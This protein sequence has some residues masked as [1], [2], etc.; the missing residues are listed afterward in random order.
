MSEPINHQDE[1]LA[2]EAL[3]TQPKKKRRKSLEI[4]E[5]IIVAFLLAVF[6]RATI[7]EARYIPSGS[8]LPSLQVGDRLIVEKLTGYVS[9]PE[10]GDILVFYPPKPGAPELNIFGK[11]MRWLGFTTEPAYIKRVIGLA[12][13]T[14]EVKEGLV[15]INGKPLDEPYIKAPPFYDYKITVPPDHLFMMGDNRNNSQDSH[16]WGPL[17]ANH[18]IGKAVFRFLPLDRVGIPD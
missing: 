17:P 18:V 7:A 4:T 3:D 10:R 2:Q 13:E 15:Y 16:I 5:T 6:I 9:S 1:S 8:M 12:G 14:L 11:A